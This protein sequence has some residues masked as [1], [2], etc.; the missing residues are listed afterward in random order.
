VQQR[1]VAVHCHTH[2]YL[3]RAAER[4][5][6]SLI[7]VISSSWSSLRGEFPAPPTSVSGIG[8]Q[9][10]THTHTHTQAHRGKHRHTPLGDKVA[11]GRKHV[12]GCRRR[13][14]SCRRRRCRS[15]GGVGAE[16][17]GG[18]GRGGR[19]RSERRPRHGRERRLRRGGR[20]HDVQCRAF[21]SICWGDLQRPWRRRSSRW[22]CSC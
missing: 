14:T 10:R 12:G 7:V 5:F 13:P 21:S 4:H 2:L 19:G 20:R 18:G 6:S 3:L 22:A 8:P 15:G 16:S 9:Q 11:K 17:G 1:T